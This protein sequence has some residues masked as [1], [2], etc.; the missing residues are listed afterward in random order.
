[1]G[2]WSVVTTR[3]GQPTVVH[4]SGL[5]RDA[6]EALYLELGGC[7]ARGH[8]LLRRDEEQTAAAKVDAPRRYGPGEGTR[9]AFGTR[10]LD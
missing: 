4:G 9:T 1:M 3:V 8:T 5:G 7:C 2:T 6:A 10:T